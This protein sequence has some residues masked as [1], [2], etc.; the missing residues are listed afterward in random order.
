MLGLSVSLIL[1]RPEILASAFGALLDAFPGPTTPYLR[2][3]LRFNVFHQ[4]SWLWSNFIFVI[5]YNS[6][7]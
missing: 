6:A 2:K 5:I 3:H 7:S 1:L 4:G